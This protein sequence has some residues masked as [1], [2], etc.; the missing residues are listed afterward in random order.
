MEDELQ[1]RASMTVAVIL[2]NIQLFV[3]SNEA[4]PSSPG[5]LS[6]QGLYTSHR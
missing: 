6:L 4:G 3:D 5:A 1:K 2:H